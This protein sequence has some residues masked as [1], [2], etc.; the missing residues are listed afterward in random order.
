MSGLYWQ[1]DG[2]PLTRPLSL[3]LRS[4]RTTGT[5]RRLD[6]SGR[7]S[8]ACRP[9]RRPRPPGAAATRLTWVGSRRVP[10]CG[11]RGVSVYESR[12]SQSG[13]QSNAR[14][15]SE[16][17]ARRPG[18]VVRS[19]ACNAMRDRMSIV[20]YSAV[21]CVASR[22]VCVT[23]PLGSGARQTLAPDPAQLAQRAAWGGNGRPQSIES[24]RTRDTDTHLKSG[25]TCAFSSVV[26]LCGTA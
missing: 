5:A 21:M 20:H 17:P 4:L 26:C 6:A 13:P 22:C 18:A 2:T 23:S 15:S 9:W 7:R 3:R 11:A 19:V 24:R 1:L 16:S 14:Q 12:E 8:I 25:V 10:S